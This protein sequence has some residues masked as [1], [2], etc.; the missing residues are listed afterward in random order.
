LQQRNLGEKSPVN[1]RNAAAG[2]LRQL[3][4]NVTASCPLRFFAYAWG[5][6]SEPF[7]TTQWEALQSFKKWGFRV[8]DQ[9]KLL[10]SLPELEEYFKEMEDKRN[11]LD[12]DID[13]IVFKLNLIR[14]QEKLWQTSRSPNWAV[15]QKFP[16]A[17]G[18]TTLM[19]I[20]ISVGRTGALTP[21]AELKPVTILRVTISNATLHNQDEVTCKDFRIGDTVVVQRAGDVIPQVVSVVVEERPQNSIPFIF[22]SACPICGSS[23]VREPK[24]AVWKCTGGLTCPAQAL[25]RLKHFV[26][27]DAFN[28]EGLGEKNIELFYEKGLLKSPTDIFRLE[29]IL[30]PPS[31][32]QQNTSDLIPLQEWDGWGELSANNLF[33]AIRA[34]R[35]ISLNR[36]IYA[37]GIPQVGEVTAKLLAHNYVTHNNWRVSMENAARKDSE[38]YQHLV[39]IDGIGSV[40]ADEIIFFFLEQH[41]L[42]VLNS[43]NKYL[44]I[45]DYLIPT[46]LTSAISGKTIVF[47]GELEKRSR[48]AAKIEAEKFGAKVASDVSARTDYVVVGTDP[49]SKLRKAQELGVVVLSESDWER[50]IYGE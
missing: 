37:L 25:E 15:A 40:V 46:M 28:I 33:K 14:Y 22:P 11:D 32:W 2:S 26:S 50:L 9:I 34:R 7:A 31:L 35:K 24:E 13:G 20:S 10:S 23:A 49:G 43:L 19:N 38:Q 48:K 41:N 4:P 21:V 29:E 45:E 1:P 44:T 16:A 42:Q 36:Y 27:R 5:E 18:I 39:S 8:C 6:C 12:F 17:R 47:T 30:S 3:D